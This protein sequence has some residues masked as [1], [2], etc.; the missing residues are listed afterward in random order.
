MPKPNWAL[1][2]AAGIGIVVIIGAAPSVQLWKAWHLSHPILCWAPIALEVA[3][4][5]L[6]SYIGA[7]GAKKRSGNG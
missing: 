5:A 1:Q 6:A 3:A 4:F 7:K 2:S